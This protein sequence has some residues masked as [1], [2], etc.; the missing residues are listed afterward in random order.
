MPGAEKYG[1]FYWCAKVVEEISKDGEIYV[2][3]DDARVIDGELLFIRRREGGEEQIN[4]AIAPG[5]WLA[6]YAASVFDGHPVAIEH[7]AGEVVDED[8]SGWSEAL[9][10]TK[11]SEPEQA[12]LKEI[13]EELQTAKP[14]DTKKL[15]ERGFEW[16]KRN[17]PVIGALSNQIR[18]WL[19]FF[20]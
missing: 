18:A 3:A 4:L 13:A 15:V 9:K 11:V 10:Q 7:W 20:N 2:H 8:Y 6:V 19:E 1:R 17:G 5:K 16:L 14:E 12:E